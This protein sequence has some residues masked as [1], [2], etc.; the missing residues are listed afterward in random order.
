MSWMQAFAQLGQAVAERLQGHDKDIKELRQQ[1]AELQQAGG[2][3]KVLA[4]SESYKLGRTNAEEEV[5][6]DCAQLVEAMG[7]QGYG[8]LAIAAA[9][10]R[11]KA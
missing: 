6:E 2:P 11:G 4:D 8:T 9:I 3:M 10:R 7:M 5:R 1:I